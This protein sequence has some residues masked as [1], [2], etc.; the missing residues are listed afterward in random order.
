MGVIN[1]HHRQPRRYSIREVKL[2]SSVGFLLGADIG[3]SRRQSQNSNLL[4][5]LETRKL[6]E[7]GKGI[8]QRDLG[9]SEEQAYL[10]LQ[11]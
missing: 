8:L 6:V 10:V 7:R 5:E 9:L 3:I 2:L 1:F 4:L 11:R